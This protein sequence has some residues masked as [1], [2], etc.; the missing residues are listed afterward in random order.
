MKSGPW[1]EQLRGMRQEWQGN[2]RLRLGV[3]VV[4]AISVLFACLTLNDWRHALHAQYQQRTLQLYKMSAL[5][6]Q[7]HWL[8]RA[9]SAKDVEKALQAEIPNATTIGLAQAE[10]QTMVRQLIDAFGRK[11]TT[12]SR[13]PVAVPGQPGLWRVPVT[14][15]GALSSTQLLE[16]LRRLE[17]ADRL[18]VID[19]SQITFTQGV[20]TVSLTLSAF[21]RVGG[22]TPQ[23]DGNGAG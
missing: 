3:L 15:R 6:G 2:P 16:M 19:E 12:E 4:V 20:P 18:V 22:G 7:E 8:S 9:Q 13:P 11:M 1:S 17:D 10:V 21:Y 14:L 5:A 23:G